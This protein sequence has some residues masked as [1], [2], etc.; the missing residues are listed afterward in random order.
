MK[1]EKIS[2]FTTRRISI[3]LR[4]LKQLA[5]EG[6]KSISSQAFAERFN[7]N[8]AQIRK[9]LAYFGE[10]G[11]RGVGYDVEKLRAHLTEILGLN[12]RYQVGIIG[13]GNLGLALANYKNWGDSSFHVVAL[14]DNDPM[15][16]GSTSRIGTNHAVNPHSIAIYDVA[17][18]PHLARKLKLDIAALAVPGDYAQAALDMCIKAG[19]KAI[20]NFAPAQL[21]APDDVQVKTVDLTI[22][23]EGLSYFLAQTEETNGKA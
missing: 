21:E 9:D 8:S 17:D 1:P 6:T 5:D 22:S 23:L 4:C 13:A 20:L 11:V 10:F 18:F 15:R 14:F 2:E 12:R 16:I 7:L 19:I 3:Y